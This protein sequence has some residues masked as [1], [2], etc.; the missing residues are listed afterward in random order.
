MNK[1]YLLMAASTLVFLTVGCKKDNN[2]TSDKTASI[3]VVNGVLKLPSL[4]LKMN[5]KLNTS[6]MASSNISKVSYGTGAFFYTQRQSTVVD[7]LSGVDSSQLSSVI[8]NLGSNSS[9]QYS[10]YLT[11]TYPNPEAVLV[12]ETNYPYIQLDKKPANADSVINVR[13]VNLCPDAQP[14]NIRLSGTTT[15][16]VSGLAYKGY[17]AFQPYP[18]RVTNYSGTIGYSILS[19]DIVENSTVLKTYSMFVYDPNRFKNVA[20][21][22]TGKKTP[23]TGEPALNVSEVNYF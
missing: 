3:Q 15:N 1:L 18:A 19:F 4:M 11:G 2:A 14:L 22:I 10:L 21:V 17:T 6:G 8:L 7:I 20:L 13:F 16:Q 23:G 9:G 5:G 12:E